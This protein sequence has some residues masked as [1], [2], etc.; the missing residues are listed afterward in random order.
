[1]DIPGGPAGGLDEGGLRT[2]E[3][4]LSASRIATGNLGK[5]ET[6]P[7]RLIP[8]KTSNSPFRSSRMMATRSRV[9]MSE[10]R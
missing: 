2:Q 7:K 10:W 8:T 5:V 6:L 3:P 1:M 9:S 4:S